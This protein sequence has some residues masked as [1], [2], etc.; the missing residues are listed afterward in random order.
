[1]SENY[2]ILVWISKERFKRAKHLK[3]KFRG[4]PRISFDDLT[5]AIV[6][7]GLRI[8]G[9]LTEDSHS[10]QVCIGLSGMPCC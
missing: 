2:L 4:K 1:M 5:S 3:L 6:M 8:I 9:V 10:T 7:K